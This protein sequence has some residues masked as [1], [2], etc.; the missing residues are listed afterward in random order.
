MILFV[1]IGIIMVVGILAIVILRIIGS[2][3]RLTHHQVSR[4]QAQYAAK[5]GI[6][7]ALDKLRRDDDAACVSAGGW[8]MQSSGAGACVVIESALPDSVSQV[9]ITVGAPGTGILGTRQVS[10]TAT[11]TYTP[12]S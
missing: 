10:A 12:S 7:Y 9:V 5:A 3:A 8:T 6:I 11:F 1:V 2:H 4:I